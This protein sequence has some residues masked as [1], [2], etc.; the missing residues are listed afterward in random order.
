MSGRVLVLPAHQMEAQC[1]KNTLEQ[2]GIE[3]ALP[4]DG[5]VD[6]RVMVGFPD[7]GPRD[8]SAPPLLVLVP[9]L[10]ESAV[11]RAVSCGA[12]GLLESNASTAALVHAVQALRRGELRLP[13]IAHP[14]G[15]V[16]AQLTERERDIVR[17][18]AAGSQNREIAET[19]GISYHTVRTHVHH[20]MEKLGVSH[21]HAV[22]AWAHRSLAAQRHA[23]ARTGS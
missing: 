5:H 11:R 7:R 21:R 17:L 9:H 13:S 4:G 16:L 2:E 14:E 15:D 22:A 10:D 6:A 19:L 1:L 23:A 18:L 20:V 8:G 12:T 3:T